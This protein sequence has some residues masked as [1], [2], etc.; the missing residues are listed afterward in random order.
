MK[1]I[2]IAILFF[3]TTLILFAGCGKEDSPEFALSEMRTALTERNFEKLSERIDADKFFAKT[4]DE[5]TEELLKK[6]SDYGKKYPEDPYFQHDENFLKKYNSEHRELH[7]KFLD[8][9]KDAYFAKI[10]EPENPEDNPHAYVANEFEKILQSSAA[11]VKETK[12]EGNHAIL[13]VE[14]RGDDSIRGK[15]IGS[16]IFKLGFEKNENDIWKFVGIE[17]LEE[18]VP[19]LVDKAEVIWITFF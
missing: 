7:L 4:Y 5:V 3:S 10:P 9:V 14:M 1:Q 18:I 13:T 19:T 16:L 11:V 17:N 12:I 2:F 8:G 6:Y 15:F